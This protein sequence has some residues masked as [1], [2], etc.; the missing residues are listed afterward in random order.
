MA[1]DWDWN[2]AAA[3]LIGGDFSQSSGEKPRLKAK[4]PEPFRLQG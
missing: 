2:A 3:T 1:S 4:L